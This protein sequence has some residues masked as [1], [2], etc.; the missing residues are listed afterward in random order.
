MRADAS[1]EIGTGHLMRCLALAQAWQD[2]GGRAFVLSAELPDGL[3]DRLG[4]EQV[5]LRRV[6]VPVGSDADAAATVQTAR[7][8]QAEWVV[9]DGYRFAP[10]FLHILR[11]SG[12]R[13]MIIDD[14]AHL[15][16]YPV[17]LLLNQN[18]GSSRA[19]YTGKIGAEVPVLLGPRFGLL[20]REFRCAPPGRDP[21][22]GRAPRVLVSM[23]GADYENYTLL[24]LQR[25]AALGLRIEAVVLA[26]AANPHVDTLK[27]YAAQSPFPCEVRVNL[28]NVAEAMDWAD[29]GITAGGS[30]VWELAAR[31]LP[32]LIGAI[33]ADQLAM[34][35][36]LRAIGGF[37]AM[38]M[39]E[40][41]SG[42][43]SAE[44]TA[45]LAA[46]PE[47]GDFDADG[48]ARVVACLTSPPQTPVSIP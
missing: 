5:Q 47:F 13:V 11:D 16:R 30:T 3:A 41:L 26:G 31:R 23:G 28:E 25:L 22:G 39:G 14:M 27:A 34:L 37:R 46:R 40:L 1:V 45:L 32:A 35:P 43:L 10:G 8:L 7:D 33:S 42:D 19:L 38:T 18:L 2:A 20:R 12:L 9:V 44:L 48:A 6:V 17:D 21:V 24:V 15:D 4:R 36:G 29:L